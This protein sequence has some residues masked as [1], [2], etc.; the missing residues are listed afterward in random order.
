MITLFDERDLVSFG[1]YMISE[2]RKDSIKNNP[3]ITNNETR[4]AILKT[5]TQFDFN[6][7]LA[8]KMK[9]DQEAQELSE[10]P[11]TLLE[12][13]EEDVEDKL[14]DEDNPK[15]IKMTPSK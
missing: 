7:W 6:N 8:L 15:I 3:E 5:V 2:Q 14:I 10:V 4:K 9:A 12:D 11:E 1:M 13:I